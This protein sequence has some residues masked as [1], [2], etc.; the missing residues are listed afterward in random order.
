V[1]TLAIRTAKVPTSTG[2][3]VQ[4]ARS[5]NQAD[6]ANDVARQVA[7]NSA[8][9][10][11]SSRGGRFTRY[12]RGVW[13]W[14]VEGKLVIGIASLHGV[15]LGVSLPPI[16]V[17]W[18]SLVAA[19]CLT[20]AGVVG[21]RVVGARSTLALSSS[22]Q[23][24]RGRSL[25]GSGLW[26]VLLWASIGTLPG[27]VVQQAWIA[28]VTWLG[29]FF[30]CICMALLTGGVAWTVA[31]IVRARQANEMAGGSNVVQPIWQRNGL[32]PVWLAGTLAWAFWEMLRG[33]IVVGGY[34]WA[35]IGHALIES[36]V[37]SAAG[38]VIGASGVSIL[39]CTIGSAVAG[40]LLLARSPVRKREVVHGG[41]VIA[42]TA[43]IWAGL[44]WLGWEPRSD[45]GVQ[46]TTVQPA[47]MQ[48]A[49]LQTNVS[50][51]NK[52]NASPQ[53]E[54]DQWI[55]IEK[56]V[57]Q[58]AQSTPKP[59]VIIWPETMLPGPT[60]EPMS[61][62]KYAEEEIYFNLSPEKN[63][64]DNPSDGNPTD[65]K[66]RPQGLE[67]KPSQIWATA[68][69]DRLLDVSEE[70][71]IP[72]LVGAEAIEGLKI[73]H[74]KRADG[75]MGIKQ[76]YAKRYNSVYIVNEGMIG[77]QRYDKTNLTPF[78][79]R[80]PGVWRFPGFSNWFAALAARG[81]RLDLSAGDQSGNVWTVFE[82]WAQGEGGSGGALAQIV[83]PICFESTNARLHRAL[84]YSKDGSR[85]S[86][87]IANVT[88]DGWFGQ[89]DMERDQHT[90][91]AR[92]R[93]VETATPTV[94]AANTGVSAIIDSNGRVIK[95]GIDG[96]SRR[97]R[98]EG[99]LTG[100]ITLGSGRTWYSSVGDGPVWGLGLAGVVL[101][102]VGWWRTYRKGK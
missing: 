80:I 12:R 84:I 27:W 87:L 56:L 99:I 22:G 25:V 86:N 51:D 89:F 71:K 32:M 68:F 67:S 52:S 8:L 28:N 102:L 1:R 16:G 53:D 4:D 55:R 30:H 49:I 31:L 43:G 74:V 42:I 37:L 47:T 50:Q 78:G 34:A 57:A 63:S 9:D 20:A 23:L 17:W 93:S 29:Y 15:L 45:G 100:Q 44:S 76:S 60:L 69:A 75:A 46:A 66:I 3:Q 19:A 72:M 40:M 36:R 88:N 85:R 62:K 24:A 58:A 26:S 90:Q 18:V 83:T 59:D 81:M 11:P 61:L 21:E 64:L 65:A 96:D 77:R 101:A 73:E 5:V 2:K 94:R 10:K 35:F 97:V 95:R 48:I 38:A 91:L 14:L 33:Q 13:A 54:V 41:A 98:V 6:Q 92:W 79:E 82:V 70:I 39:A 7:K